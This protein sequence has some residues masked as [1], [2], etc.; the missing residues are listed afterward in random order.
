M[1]T[2]LSKFVVPKFQLL[3][4][5]AI[6]TFTMDLVCSLSKYA[7]CYKDIQTRE[8]NDN[9]NIT[10][11]VCDLSHKCKHGRIFSYEAIGSLL[12]GGWIKF[13][14]NFIILFYLVIAITTYFI[15]IKVIIL[16]VKEVVETSNFFAP[17]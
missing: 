6:S 15:I 2:R 5:V 8:N 9:G 12:F 17:Y 1:V 3:L 10:A 16:K 7:G 13:F 14:I 11:D 4:V